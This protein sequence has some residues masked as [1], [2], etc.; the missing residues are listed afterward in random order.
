SSLNPSSFGQSVTFT[1]TVA[2]V[3]GL[4]IPTGTI[5]FSDGS[6][7]LASPTLNA[8]GVATYTTVMLSAGSHTLSAVYGGDAN[9]Q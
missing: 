8:S 7:L 2:G 4:A 9:Y 3:S 1:F 5:A 6:T